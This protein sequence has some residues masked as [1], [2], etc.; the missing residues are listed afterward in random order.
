V[1]RPIL[2]VEGFKWK[3]DRGSQRNWEIC[4]QM[5]SN[6]SCHFKSSLGLKSALQQTL[7]FARP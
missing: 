5:P 1:G 2:S 4:L 3:K 7:L 6:S